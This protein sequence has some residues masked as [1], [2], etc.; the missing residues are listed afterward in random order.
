MNYL[1]VN[2]NT[3]NLK[4]VDMVKNVRKL[5]QFKHSAE[6]TKTSQKGKCDTGEKYESNSTDKYNSSEGEEA[7]SIKLTDTNVSAENHVDKEIPATKSK[8]SKV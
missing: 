4:A 7:E 3:L 6:P 2:F 1:D 5:C 8:I